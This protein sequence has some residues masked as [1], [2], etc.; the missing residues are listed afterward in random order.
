L[1][2]VYRI[3]WAKQARKDAVNIERAELKKQVTKILGVVARNPYLTASAT[4]VR[5]E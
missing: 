4:L 1:T 2:E 5:Y 3:E